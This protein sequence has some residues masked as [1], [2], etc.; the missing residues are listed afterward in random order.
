M[1]YKRIPEV[2]KNEGNEKLQLVKAS[3]DLCVLLVRT[4]WMQ[5]AYSAAVGA[6]CVEVLLESSRFENLR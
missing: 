1:Y 6:Y 4:L 5:I 2:A 3:L